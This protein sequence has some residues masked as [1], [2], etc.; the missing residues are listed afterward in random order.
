MASTAA[1]YPLFVLPIRRDRDPAAPAVEGE[2]DAAHEFY[3]LQWTFHDVPPIPSPHDDLFA[4]P[5]ASRASSSNSNPPTSTI[6]LTPLQEYKMR[7]SFATPYLVLTNYT[8]LAHSHGVVLLRG[9]ITP[10][11]AAGTAGVDGKYLLGQ[12]DAYRLSMGVQKFYLWD[13]DGGSDSLEREELVKAF[14]KTP[15]KFA[16]EELLKHAN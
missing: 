10:P 9:E 16:W 8:D 3:F 12:E 6:M 4:P 15:D 14:H 7:G 2:T 5:S 1:K 11:A 13:T